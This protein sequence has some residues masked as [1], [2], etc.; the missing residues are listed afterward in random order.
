[1]GAMKK[2]LRI[3]YLGPDYGTSRHRADALRRIGHSVEIIDPWKFLPYSGFPR[4]LIAKLVIEFGAAPFEPYIRWR[5]FRLIK[6]RRF[7]LMWSNQ[8]NLI[9]PVTAGLL[10]NHC[11]ATVTYAIDDPFGRRDKRRFSLYRQS[12]KHFD[13]VAVV[14]EPNVAEAKAMGAPSVLLVSRSADEVAHRPLVLSCEERA[15]WSSQVAFIGTWMPER[16]AFLA[17]LIELGVPIT[18]RGDRWRKA[19]EWPVLK[20]AWRGPGIDGPDY[21]KAI[22]CAKIC[23]GLLSK[24]NRDLHTTRTAEIPY[25]GSVLCAE[26]T[27][28]HLKM[29][30][31]DEEAVF[32][33]TPEQCAEKCL[34]LLGNE[35]RCEAIARAG[36]E[37]CIRD[38][39]LNERALSMILAALEGRSP[40]NAV[41]TGAE[42]SKCAGSC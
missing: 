19:K 7:D 32:W 10:R 14:R 27:S 17:R 39:Y 30:R 28:E 13:L 24:G 4:K 37:R 31:E 23:L 1:M 38:G 41:V 6:W 42:P 5:M 20:S 3:L 11:R 35:A 16:G 36:R 15:E 25:I 34:N 8:C 12:M 40:A 26:R 33:S 18:I 29:Y 2:N 9:G 22:Q 21:V